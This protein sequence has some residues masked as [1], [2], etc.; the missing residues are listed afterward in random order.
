MPRPVLPLRPLPLAPPP[1]PV[2][3]SRTLPWVVGGLVVAV[4]AAIGFASREAGRDVVLSV[5]GAIQVVPFLAVA[6]V[7]IVYHLKYRE[8]DD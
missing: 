5:V 4:A 7:A 6:V 8:W 2:R 1:V 3:R